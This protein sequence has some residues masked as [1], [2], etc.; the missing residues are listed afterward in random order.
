MFSGD[1]LEKRGFQVRQ[2]LGANPMDASVVE[3]A[4]EWIGHCLKTHLACR[5]LEPR[6]VM[7]PTRLLDV[8][9]WH[10]TGILKII[11]VPKGFDSDYVALSYCWGEKDDWWIQYVEASQQGGWKIEGDKMPQTYQDA[12]AACVALSYSYLWI[13]CLCIKQGDRNDW[14]TER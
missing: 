5:A 8:R 7:C 4:K 2:R 11:Q 13:D 10:Q 14:L 3:K 6:Q 1:P 12:I 9:A